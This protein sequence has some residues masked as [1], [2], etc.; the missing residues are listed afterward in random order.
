MNVLGAVL[1]GSPKDSKLTRRYRRRLGLIGY[2]APIVWANRHKIRSFA[3][4]ALNRAQSKLAKQEAAVPPGQEA[5]SQEAKQPEPA[6]EQQP[7][8]TGNPEQ[9]A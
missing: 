7:P 2:L 6:G 1:V 4:S 8:Q 3:D 9:A 5:P